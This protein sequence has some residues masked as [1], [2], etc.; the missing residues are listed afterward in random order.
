VD[1]KSRLVLFAAILGLHAAAMPQEL[2]RCPGPPILYTDQISQEEARQKNCRS[3]TEATSDYRC[4]IQ[5]V[6]EAGDERA[7]RLR[8][9]YVGREF[10][11][12]RRT[13]IM[14][15]ALKNSYITKPQVIDD[16]STQN[17]FKV[18]TTL[19]R[20]EGRGPGSNVHV[21][22]VM[23]YVQA[24]RKPFVFLDNDETYFGTCIHF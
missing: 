1:N 4:T 9:A 17:A 2:Y 8:A 3:V 11:V 19:R 18:V 14:A 10:T 12:E 21:L 5:R 16:G 22:V 13:G 23:E 24:T 20:G 15:G 6:S 7:E